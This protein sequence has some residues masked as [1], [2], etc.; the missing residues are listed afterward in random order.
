[1]HPR[2]PRPAGARRRP[3]LREA[4]DRELRPV[5]RSDLLGNE[6]LPSARW[7][8]VMAGRQRVAG[9]ITELVID[10]S[11]KRTPDQCRAGLVRLAHR[12]ADVAERVTRKAA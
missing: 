3:T 9:T 7:K 8:D 4:I 2:D 5:L 1:M 12:I 11:P 10:A 6:P